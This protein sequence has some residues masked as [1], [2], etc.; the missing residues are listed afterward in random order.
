MKV[1]KT[2]GQRIKYLMTEFALSEREFAPILG[3]SQPAV[4]RIAND[5]QNLT[6]EQMR[7]LSKYFKVNLNWLILGMGDPFM[8]KSTGLERIEEK[9]DKIL[10]K[11]G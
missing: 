6:H 7:N 10:G 4:N 1:Y 5:S 11:I 9:I 2:T 3:T 8:D